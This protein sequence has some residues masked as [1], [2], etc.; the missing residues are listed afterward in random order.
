VELTLGNPKAGFRGVAFSPDG[1]RLAAVGTDGLVR[2]WESAGGRPL[3]VCAAP[4]RPGSFGRVAF[5][6]DGKYLVAGGE[7]VTVWD[8]ATGK[9]LRTLEGSPKDADRLT[10]S[11]D[12]KLVAAAARETVVLWDFVSGREVASYPVHG[13]ALLV[14]L[15]FSPDGTRLA[16]GHGRGVDVWEVGPKWQALEAARR[17]QAREQVEAWHRRQAVLPSGF[18]ARFHCSWLIAREPNEGRHY[19]LRADANAWL[20]RWDEAESDAAR[21]VELRPDE[22]GLWERLALL[23]LRAGHDARYRATCA[24][25]VKRLGQTTDPAAANDV[26]WICCFAPGATSDPQGVVAVAERAV[27]K[28]ARWDRLGTLGA[29]LCRGGREEAVGR[30]REAIK[31]QQQGG[32]AAH[33]FLLAISL[34]HLNQTDQARGAFDRGRA[35]EKKLVPQ[36]WQA[37]LLVELLR[38]E[39]EGLLQEKKP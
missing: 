3:V 11:R 35:Q 33:W 37:R 31:A 10:F 9:V 27:A 20:D 24:A 7:A 38:A 16:I 6:P 28:D 36:V 14:D 2:V 32:A 18:P 8:A 22:T 26:A 4:E 39:A 34:H 30:L 19:A 29:A 13:N 5:S 15:A 21:A 12:G 23:Q 17:E 1:A 25:L